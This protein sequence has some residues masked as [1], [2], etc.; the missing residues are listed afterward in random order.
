MIA[1]HIVTP[2]N[3]EWGTLFLAEPRVLSFYGA[4]P[5][6]DRAK[7]KWVT[8]K[9]LMR[10]LIEFHYARKRRMD[11]HA[12]DPNLTFKELI[13]NFRPLFV[14]EHLRLHQY[15][16]KMNVATPFLRVKMDPD[17]V[18]LLD[19]GQISPEGAKHH[20]PEEV[21]VPNGFSER[22]RELIIGLGMYNIDDVPPPCQ[23]EQA[24]R[25]E[26]TWPHLTS[27]AP[28][29]LWAHSLAET[30]HVQLFLSK[31]PAARWNWGDVITTPLGA[32][33]ALVSKPQVAAE[34]ESQ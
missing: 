7:W 21:L 24:E 29:P 8:V 34:Q 14:L 32:K 33:R 23:E 5:G 13:E 20:D 28:P 27:A 18:W 6:N 19:C 26:K 11:I 12:S 4:R 1:E 16:Q 31:G 10:S 3:P 22:V 9:E 30:E 25:I 15:L 17:N 2:G